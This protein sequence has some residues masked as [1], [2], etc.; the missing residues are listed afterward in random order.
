MPIP[1]SELQATHDAL[2]AASNGSSRAQSQQRRGKSRSR[3]QSRVRPSPNQS[4]TQVLPTGTSST[5]KGVQAPDTSGRQTRAG[6]STHSRATSSHSSPHIQSRGRRLP[7]GV[8]PPI[9][10]TSTIT[11]PNEIAK[12]LPNGNSEQSSILFQ[13]T[14]LSENPLQPQSQDNSN[15]RISGLSAGAPHSGPH[16]QTHTPFQSQSPVY[17]PPMQINP[18][19][20]PYGYGMVPPNAM[21][22]PSGGPSPRMSGGQLLSQGYP[23]YPPYGQ[24]Q[25]L[26]PGQHT[27]PYFFPPVQYQFYSPQSQAQPLDRSPEGRNQDTMSRLP[28][29]NFAPTPP[30]I[31]PPSATRLPPPDQSAPLSGYR[32]I[33]TIAVSPLLLASG[34]QERQRERTGGSESSDVMFGSVGEPGGLKSPSPVLSQ[35]EALAPELREKRHSTSFAVGYDGASSIR[36][37]ISGASKDSTEELTEAVKVIDLTDKSPKWEFGT[38]TSPGGEVSE[39]VE[40]Q[41]PK[42]SALGLEATST[43]GALQ[44]VVSEQESQLLQPQ[45]QTMLQ[46]P[47]PPLPLPHQVGGGYPM[48]PQ[49]HMMPL[50]QR[51]PQAP[52]QPLPHH[53]PSLAPLPLN[54]GFV[55]PLALGS[56]GPTSVMPNSHM[57]NGDEWEVRDFG[58]GFGPTSGSG[59]V[60]ER[61]R[62]DRFDRD[63]GYR[64][65][66]PSREFSGNFGGGR[67]RRNTSAGPYFEGGRGMSRR[68]RGGPNGYGRGYGGRGFSSRGGSH[69]LPRHHQSLSVS[70]GPFQQQGLGLAQPSQTSPDMANG[71][72]APSS[73]TTHYIPSPYSQFIPPPQQ[74]QPQIQTPPQPPMQALSPQPSI[75]HPIPAPI[76]VLSF[77]L[78]PTRRYLLGQVEYYFSLQNLAS[79]FFLRKQ[80]SRSC[81]YDILTLSLTRSILPDGLARMVTYPPHRIFQSR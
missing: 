11:G 45:P 74:M 18:G 8:V 62:E 46:F 27:F 66:Q 17:Y 42:T 21:Y 44:T 57:I 67:G 13:P 56:P 39:T 3:R 70:T 80:V 19:L 26:P 20:P 30:P 71:Y 33:P 5:S 25:H 37:K 29:T 47:P 28:S 76:T 54:P 72:Y 4:S 1:Q 43:T 22:A 49:V 14:S 50:Q 23:L 52:M 64:E 16:S 10:N 78:D 60:P 35:I 59:F 63:G 38:S 2:V 61:M 73:T 77:P 32:E 55:S 41:E 68:G 69:G 40:D 36:L 31:P 15:S 48:G 12:T 79:D 51:S 7:D 58:Y 24:P 34:S 81:I 53:V 6:S 75:R 65:Q 9:P